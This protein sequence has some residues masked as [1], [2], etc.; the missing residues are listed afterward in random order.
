MMLMKEIY[1]KKEKRIII[2]R[3]FDD[4]HDNGKWFQF[5]VVIT[6]T[7]K[8]HVRHLLLLF[9]VDLVTN[10]LIWHS[11]GKSFDDSI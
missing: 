11:I 3:S 7:E 9:Y 2:S 4:N 6:F 8:F 10:V 5:T 1:K